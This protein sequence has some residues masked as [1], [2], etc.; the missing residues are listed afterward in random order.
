MAKRKRLTPA[1]TDYLSTD[2]DARQ[3]AGPA[4]LAPASPVSAVP[5]ARV[6]GDAATTAA[7]EEVS[8][9]L[10]S[11]RAEGRLIQRIALDDIVSDYLVRDRVVMHGE[12]LDALI[13]SLRARGQQTPIEVTA[14]G[15][16]SNPGQYGLISGARRLRALRYLFE[17][18]ADPQFASVLAILREPAT[19]SDA[20]VAM[21]EENEIRVGLSYYER[22]RITQRAVVAGVYP[23]TQRALQGLFASA[24]RAKRSKIKS[25]ITIVEALDGVLSFPATLGERAGL[26]LAR[27]LEERPE[28]QALLQQ[29]L[30][31]TP[32]ENA[33]A[34]LKIIQAVLV[35]KKPAKKSAPALA[36]VEEVIPGVRLA[37]S[38]RGNAAKL[39]LSGAGMTPEFQAALIDWMKANA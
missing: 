11:A 8:E 30:D 33:E 9:A 32:A 26:A 19:S 13:A 31:A 3:T 5:I 10:R 23:D 39:T 21:V 27:A 1:K 29:R 4:S 18:T 14:L 6:A 22:A 38:G 15:T 35:T 37:V 17:E 16:G 2:A 28:V 36:P 25:F 12:D 7:L 34:E 24:S 20:Y